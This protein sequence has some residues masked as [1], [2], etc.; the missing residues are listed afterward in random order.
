MSRAHSYLLTHRDVAMVLAIAAI[1]I[2]AVV[3]SVLS[4]T[5]IG[6]NIDTD[7][8]LRV[9]G[10]ANASST[11]QAAG[12]S[13]FYGTLSAGASTN[14]PVTTFNVTGSGYFTAGLGVGY[15]TTGSGNLLV[16]DLAVIRGRLGVNASTSPAVEF[17]VTGSGLISTGL[18]VGYATT[19][20]GHIRTSGLTVLGS[21]LGVNA[22]TSP[23][24]EL[25]LTGSAALGS[26]AT[27]TVSLESTAASTGGCLEFR[28]GVAGEST[29]FVRI[30]VG[31]HGATTSDGIG[32]SV[33][34]GSGG[35]GL[36][37][38]EEG[39]CQ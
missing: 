19:G 24:Y 36:L 29:R 27:T 32:P 35:R 22:S 13:L 9:G 14:S 8:T 5:T 33:V 23:Y 15:A 28:S 10:A 37:V 18:G 12:T 25:G 31:G 38:I 39:R 7:G 2:F 6:S 1:F 21:R 20:S 4:A 16:N 17:G 11:L 26:G 3:Y 30:Y 34:L